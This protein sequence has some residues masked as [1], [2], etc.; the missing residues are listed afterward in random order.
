MTVFVKK[1][2]GSSHL[3]KTIILSILLSCIAS[4]KSPA[5]AAL[6]VEVEEF[7]PEHSIPARHFLAVTDPQ[8]KNYLMEFAKGHAPKKLLN[9]KNGTAS[10]IPLE[11]G[12]CAETP[13]ELCMSKV[14]KVYQCPESKQVR[15]AENRA[16]S[17]TP[18]RG[19]YHGR[20]PAL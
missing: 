11:K 2:H 14:V 1:K 20:S 19:L 3:L 9:L 10:F 16:E 18:V 5:L 12:T 8:S 17:C 13:A 6:W 4:A 15:S 7:K